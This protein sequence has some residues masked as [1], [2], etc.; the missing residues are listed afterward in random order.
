MISCSS[1]LSSYC[2]KV[3]HFMKNPFSHLFSCLQTRIKQVASANLALFV[4]S[5]SLV[6]YHPVVFSCGFWFG[7]LCDDKITKEIIRRINNIYYSCKTMWQTIL[8]LGA[9]A[10]WVVY[11]RPL[12][13]I[14]ATAY[15]SMQWGTWFYQMTEKRCTAQTNLT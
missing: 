13:S 15:V 11:T 10:L 7:F 5:L 8:V 1:H 14:L 4:I 6:R 9:G 2:G 3:I 12:S